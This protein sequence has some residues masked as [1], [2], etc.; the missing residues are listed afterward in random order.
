MKKYAQK[1]LFVDSGRAFPYTLQY[2]QD[3]CILFLAWVSSILYETGEKGLCMEP[4]G[5]EQPTPTPTSEVG[6]KGGSVVREK[7]G[8]DYYRQ[9]GK[10]GGTALKEQRGSEYYRTIARKGGAANKNKY[11]V[12]HFAEMGKKGGNSTKERQDPDFYSRIGRMGGT[13]KKH[14]KTPDA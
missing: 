14:K 1:S 13:A 12:E 11:G 4:E 6:R 3:A 9:I 2:R 10:K 8:E 7:Y 5:A